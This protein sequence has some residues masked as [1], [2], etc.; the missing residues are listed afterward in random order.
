M[1]K[2]S[3][4]LRTILL[5]LLVFS[6]PLFVH[7]QSVVSGKITDSA[8]TAL[9]GVSIRIKG[10][11]GGT[12]TDANGSFTIRATT[13]KPVLIVSGVGYNTQEVAVGS[14]NTVTVSLTSTNSVMTDVVVVGYTQQ[15]RAKTTASVSK[16][17][18]EELRNTSNPNPVQAIQGKIAGVSVPIMS[19]QPGGGAA[20]IIIRGGTKLNTYGSG[21]GNS[22]G[23][24]F[25]NADPSSPLV[26]VDGVFRSL[27]DINPDNIESFQV[28]KDAASTAIYGARGANGVIVIKTKG[29][30]FNSKANLTVN[31]RTTW[32]TKARDYK[33]LNAQQYLTL[34]R[35]TVNNTFDPLD[36]NNL[37]NNGGF[38]AG[39]RVYT[40]KGQYGTNINLTALYDN[41]VA[42]EGQA[43]VDNL[44]ARGWQT[45]DD[46]INP[47]KK[48][49]YADNHYQDLLW[50]T[51]LTENYNVGINGG[52]DR[53]NYNVSLGHIDQA[54]IFVGTRYRRYDA[55]GNF[56]F[57]ASDN[58]RIDAMVNYQNV[59]PNYV[60]AYQN[61]LT[62]GTRLT[63]LIRIYKDDGNPTPGE[64][65]TA[66]NR[67]HT[68]K[69]DDVRASTER[70]I[71]RL[72]GDLTI[73]KGLH[74]KP[75]ISYLMQDYRYLFMRKATP[76]SEIQPPTQRQKNDS[77]D[78]FRQL[79]VDQI[80]QYDFNL[81]N[82]HQ[83]TL[84]AGFNYTR[85]TNNR[86]SIGSQRA[87]NDY[88]YTISEPST[89]VIN[90]VT[91]TNVT[92]FGSYLPESRSA[93]FFGQF[94]YDYKGKYLA[95]GS[96]RYDGFSNF[97][98]ENKFAWFPSVSVGW[99]VHRENF[100]H[101]QAISSLKLRASWGGSGTS[102][103]Q[104]TDT[105]GGYSS[106][107]YAIG[108]GILRTNLSNPNLVWEGT[109]TTDLAF[110]A[111]L[112]NDRITLTVDVYNKLTKNR[113]ASK[114]L[115]SEAPFP[116]ITYNNGVLQNKGV[117]VELGATVIK[118]NAFTWRTN[119]SFAYNRTVIK[120]LPDNG[121]AKNRQGGDLVWDAGSKTLVEAGGFAEG[122]RPYGMWAYKV[123]GVFAT[124]AEAAA[125][126]A[127]KK[128]NLASPPGISVG[129][130]AGDF[131]FDDV[132]GDGVIDTKDQVFM[133]YR[134]P[135]KIGGMQ[136][137]FSYKAFSLRIAVDYAMGHLI[138]NGA[139]ARSL[140]QGRAFNE[141]APSQA[142]GPDIWQKSGDAGKK[143]ARFSFA[144]FDFGQRNY[145]RLG[146]LGNNNSYASD[147]SALIEKGDFLALREI[148]LS[149][150][151]SKDLLRKIRSTGL[152]L[153]ASVY[154]LGYLT[155]YTGINPETYTGFDEAGYP[156]PR[157]FSLG[158][159][160]RF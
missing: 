157:Q 128:D 127:T 130:H 79:M 116:S 61:D 91:T 57:K 41:I 68:L 151:V 60:E 21:L 43:Y 129:K 158:A 110:D 106:A 45:M 14:Q 108:S 134:T 100:W 115:P 111:G 23:N 36:K 66:R 143:Y 72:A 92:D 99:N 123:L 77:V 122:E 145:I 125:W 148:S 4:S 46:P 53:A 156:R 29:G 24:P 32:E 54:G 117:E 11:S 132:N 50:N 136:N 140:G 139:L 8:G 86:V 150:E 28:M 52:S 133:G 17:A 96:L 59:Q 153:F 138:S 149:Y 103:L 98:P 25:A 159:T 65:F 142:L 64:V 40:A 126:N 160:L 35:T 124:E 74:F 34:A 18:P 137:T 71:S 67:F 1:N 31:H 55:L 22:K 83:F 105:Y 97:A 152:N 9:E 63:P 19:G 70:I 12:V 15:S 87:T 69:Y 49:L 56:S 3:S 42:I 131:I 81:H 2:K 102:D 73:A 154:N 13:A 93:S 90:G 80:L 20:N 114:P 89:T 107:T 75:S 38:S 146:T 141:G 7:A 119:F 16:L 76:A 78:N 30:K 95:S 144:D 27:D 10:A 44:L 121:R 104:L 33:Y 109:Q 101:S 48:L 85:L 113:L 94:N 82:E 84:L 39:T 37:L 51:G 112:L 120:D 26:V 147:V 58:F 62:R 47:G 118:T 6:L 5:L 135:D 88:V 155:K